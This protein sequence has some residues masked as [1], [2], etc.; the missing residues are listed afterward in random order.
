[1]TPRPFDGRSHNRILLGILRALESKGMTIQDIE[2]QRGR[3]YAGAQSQ[4]NYR[5]KQI[6]HSR[7]D[8]NRIV[9]LKLNLDPNVW[10]KD[11]PTQEYQTMVSIQL[12]KLR[13]RGYLGDW[14]PDRRFRIHRLIK[15]ADDLIRDVEDQIRKNSM[16]EP[17]KTGTDNE[18]DSDK[19]L[20][21]AFVSIVRD[22]RKDNT[23]KFALARAMLDYCH[24]NGMDAD[25]NI[26]YSYLASK[27]LEYYWHQE[28][29][30]K[31]K[32]NFNPAKPPNV[33]QAISEVFD[34]N[35]KK[36][37]KDL[38]RSKKIQAEKIILEK[39]FGH[40]RSKTSI[41]IHK[42]Q[43]INN[44]SERHF[45]KYDDNIQMIQLNPGVITFFNKNY[46]ILLMSVIM[47]WA[48]FLEK[49]NESLPRLVTKVEK[50]DDKRNS[51]SK[52]KN[53]Y[54]DHTCKCFYCGNILVE[55]NIEVDHFIPW[56]YM[57]DDDAWNLVISCKR[58][59]RDKSNHLPTDKMMSNL[60]ERNEKYRG[61][62]KELKLSL[63]RL[64]YK[65]KWK[66]EIHNCYRRCKDQGFKTWQ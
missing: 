61:E 27:F 47:E 2:E 64:E 54:L 20:M 9:A 14:N 31:I 56:T 52:F 39:V 7:E 33:I 60:I 63:E 34:D 50:N 28:Y 57:F 32:Q 43:K 53:M 66:D 46:R 4:E 12:D 21:E 5:D 37:F 42:F 44:V 45:Y 17:T 15:P 62:I 30:F 1:M 19:K 65:G 13:R 58:C 40:A 41:V 55:G 6:W 8:L 3:K 18:H 10:G 49:V 51:L 35:E 29:R 11:R 22:S 38:P 25:P 23:Y 36:R 24:E 48:K 59:N 26:P 16:L